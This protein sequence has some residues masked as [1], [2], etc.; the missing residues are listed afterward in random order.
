MEQVAIGWGQRLRDVVDSTDL[1]V[2]GGLG[3]NI[4]AN[5]NFIDR[6]GYR[7]LFVQP[8]ASDTGI[9]LGCALWG[10]K[11]IFGEE[12][13]FTMNHAF[14]GRSYSELEIRV[15]LEK[16]AEHIAISSG[17]DVVGATTDLLCRGEIGAWFEGGSEYG[18]RALG[19][20]S[21]IA[22]PRRPEMKDI[23]NRRVKHREIWRPFGCSILQE[24]TADYFELTTD[25]PFML[26]AAQA[27]AGI[28]EAIPS[29]VHVDNTSRIQTLT[30][31]QNGRFYHLV[32]NF[33]RR[34]GV[35][36]LLN[37]SF[38][39]AGDPIVEGLVSSSRVRSK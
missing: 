3:L 25:S 24:R 23:L 37:T 22:D 4:D 1:C 11:M 7:R 35:P 21:I 12:C 6:V 8:A 32:S 28:R 27:R 20:R 5:R 18:P 29:V 36:I 14:L 10:A 9:A 16:R 17:I 38:N 19:H 34:T 30:Q 31:E 2:A 33:G 15:A 26:L 39:V 13:T